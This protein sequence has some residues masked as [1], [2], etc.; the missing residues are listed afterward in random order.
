[1]SAPTYRAWAEYDNGD[2]AVYE[3]LTRSRAVWRDAWHTRMS[4]RLR[5]RRWGWDMEP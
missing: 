5:L 3:G 4:G 2:R 1:M